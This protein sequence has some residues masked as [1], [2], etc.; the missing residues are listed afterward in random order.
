M[1]EKEMLREDEVA[2]THTFKV[3]PKEPSKTRLEQKQNAD[4]MREAFSEQR[5]KLEESERPTFDDKA[6]DF[7]SCSSLQAKLS[8]GRIIEMRE[9]PMVQQFNIDN[10]FDLQAQSSRQQALAVMH[11]TKIDD[12]DIRLPGSKKEMLAIAN[13]LKTRGVNEVFLLYQKHFA[14]IVNLEVL[15]KNL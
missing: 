8:D 10:W 14:G 13:K 9:P 3:T 7:E 11:V 15:K 1:T 12:E 4:L 2:S 6:N 5:R